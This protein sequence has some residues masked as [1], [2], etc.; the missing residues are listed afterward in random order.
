MAIRPAQR[1]LLVG[2]LIKQYRVSV[3]RA[4]GVCQK[5]R[6]TWYHT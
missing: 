2:H 6:L 5:A 1:K 3:Q 4:C